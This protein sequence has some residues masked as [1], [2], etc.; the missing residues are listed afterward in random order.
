MKITHLTF[1]IVRNYLVL[2]VFVLCAS[3]T[4]SYGN[5]EETDLGA[6]MK[7]LSAD[8]LNADPELIRDTFERY[9][10]SAL[11]LNRRIPIMERDFKP[12]IKGRF[13]SVSSEFMSLLKTFTE[14]RS[15]ELTKPLSNSV[16]FRRLLMSLKVAHQIVSQRSD[17]FSVR[18]IYL[19]MLMNYSYFDSHE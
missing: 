4:P 8:P 5:A 7:L 15:Q 11:K 16:D 1:R 9:L 19:Y 14:E 17:W 12:P 2:S 6:V 10:E 18:E 13:H 3:I